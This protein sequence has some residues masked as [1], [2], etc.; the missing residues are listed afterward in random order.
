[1][2]YQK[3]EVTNVCAALALVQG[4]MKGQSQMP[5]NFLLETVG[6]YEADE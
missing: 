4:G 1:M 2:K 6:A 3:A 5:D